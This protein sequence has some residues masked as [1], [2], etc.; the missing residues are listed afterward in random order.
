MNGI[1]KAL[2]AVALMGAADA[3]GIYSNGYMKN[4]A[5]YTMCDLSPNLSSQTGRL[6]RFTDGVVVMQQEIVDGTPSTTN[7]ST[8][9]KRMREGDDFYQLNLVTGDDINARR[10]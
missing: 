2:A 3:T 9:I 1:V 4:R 10:C 5:V 7:I 6:Q 8:K